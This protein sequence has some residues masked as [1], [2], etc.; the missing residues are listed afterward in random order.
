[1]FYF[2]ARALLT[3][4]TGGGFAISSLVQWGVWALA[5]ELA[6]LIINFAALMCSHTAAFHTEKNLKMAALRHL[7]RMPM[8][9]FEENPSGKLRKIIDENSAQMETYL[10]HQLPDLVSAQ[11]TTVA[12]LVLMLAMD[13]RI[14]LPLIVLMLASF[15]CQMTMMG[16]KTMN[17][18]KRYQD[19]QEEMNHEAVEYVRGISV[20]KVFGQSV[21]SIRRFKEAINAYRDDALAFTMACKPGYV[22]FN[23]VVNAAFLVLIPAALIG[24]T[25]AGDLTAF[26]ENF[27]FYL[28]FAPACASVLNKI[29][30]MSNY[31]MQAMESMRRI[32]TILLAREQS[33]AQEP[34]MAQGSDICF[35]H[36]TFTY[37]TGEQP[38]VSDV[39]LQQKPEPLRHWWDIPAPARPPSGPWSPAFMMCRRG[40]LRWAAWNFLRSPDRKSWE[41]IAFVFQNPKL[42]KATLEENI[43]GGCKNASRE[44]ILRAAHLAQCDDILA[45]L[46]KGIDSIVGGKG[47][48]LSGGEVQRVAIARAILKDAPVII[49]DEVTAFADPENEVQIQAALKELTKGKN[50]HYDCAPAV[51]HSGCGSDP[52]N[53]SRE[54]GRT[55]NAS[56]TAW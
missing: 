52:G 11:V 49:L 36:V 4:L 8:G 34:Q 17:F 56:G 27:L 18:M 12:S 26:I 39:S 29:M 37:P 32:D 5:L 7:S 23:T 48:Y 44:D 40:A 25:S 54:S 41:K 31:K 53:E 35:E 9:Y 55:G 13:W 42:L 6:G 3:G 24:M 2:A 16:E 50:S 43:R 46:P 33:E 51:H 45:K 38:A 15:A 20:I 10:A 14:G 22:G 21:H 47:V 30:Y 28:I 1:M 19:A